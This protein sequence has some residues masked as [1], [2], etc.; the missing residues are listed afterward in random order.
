M[1]LGLLNSLTFRCLNDECNERVPL[2]QYRDHL[3]HKCKVMRYKTIEEVS[4]ALEKED[5]RLAEAIKQRDEA[6]AKNPF[7]DLFFTGDLEKLYL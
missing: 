4:G 6:K 3:L 5:T 1:E 7:H 2:G